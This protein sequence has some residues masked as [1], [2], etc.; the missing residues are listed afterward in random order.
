MLVLT[1]A[2]VYIAE[3]SNEIQAAQALR[4]LFFIH[5]DPALLTFPD[6]R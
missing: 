6:L 2:H 5:L 4:P 1:L 3:K